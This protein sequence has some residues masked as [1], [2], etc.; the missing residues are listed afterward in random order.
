LLT[1]WI[2]SEWDAEPTEP[3]IERR[4]GVVAD[5]G[6]TAVSVVNDGERFEYVV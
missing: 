1:R 4:G 6:D 3:L 5:A 2:F